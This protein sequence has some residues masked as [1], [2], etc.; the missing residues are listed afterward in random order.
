MAQLVDRRPDALL[1]SPARLH[2]DLGVPVQLLNRS[3]EP[4]IGE[5][6]GGVLGPEPTSAGEAGR[7]RLQA[8]VGNAGEEA[9]PSSRDGEVGDVAEAA[10]E[11]GRGRGSPRLDGAAWIFAD[12]GESTDHAEGGEVDADRI[13]AGAADRLDERG[14]HLAARC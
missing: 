13:E 9:G 6:L 7:D 10:V 12:A 3:L 11:D 4:D 5:P 14:H 2:N 8:D 1:E